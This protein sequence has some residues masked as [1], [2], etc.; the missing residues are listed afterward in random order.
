MPTR[1]HLL[2]LFVLTIVIL[3]TRV[4]SPAP[5]MH[6]GAMGR[7][8]TVVLVHGLGS[9]PA[10]WLPV[11]R[12]LGSHHRVVLVSLPGHADAPMAEPLTLERAAL[13]L[14]AGLERA[15]GDEPVV[16]VGH[17]IGGVIATAVALRR[18]ERVRGLVLVETALAPMITG[19]ERLLLEQQLGSDFHGTLRNL[20]LGFGRDSAQGVRLWGEAVRLEPQALGSWV[21]LALDADVSHAAAGLATPV[22][23]VLAERS[24]GRDEPWSVAAAVLGYSWVPRLEA[25]RIGGLG[26]FVMLD[27]P[28]ALARRIEQFAAAPGARAAAATTAR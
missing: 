19:E 26:H 13:A 24:W 28:E 7:G 20:W 22:L 1:H 21:Q 2:V 25:E 14:E 4:L 5:A 15:V 11:A 17:S 27:E 12:R 3:V 16:L 6:A 8:P 18:P 10:H 9:T 23:A